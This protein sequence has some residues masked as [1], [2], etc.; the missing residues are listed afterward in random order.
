MSFNPRL[1]LQPPDMNSVRKAWLQ[2]LLV[3]VATMNLVDPARAQNLAGLSEGELRSLS[4]LQERVYLA[5]DRAYYYPGETVWYRAFMGYAMPTLRDT[6]SKVL[7]IEWIDAAGVIRQTQRVRIEKGAAWGNISLP[8]DYVSGTH[9]LRAYT[10]WMRNYS[11]PLFGKPISVLDL[12]HSVDPSKIDTVV[13]ASPYTVNFH[14]GKSSFRARDLVTL[15]ISVADGKGVPVLGNF[16]ISVVDTDAAVKIPG[17]RSILS[18]VLAVE[19]RPQVNELGYPI[20]RGLQIKGVVKDFRDRPASLNVNVVQ[21]RLED[22]VSFESDETG[23]FVLQDLNF[24][25][26][27]DFTFQATNKKSKP[28]GHVS[29]DPYVPP[30][31]SGPDPV[32]SLPYIKMDALQRIQNTYKAGDDVTVLEGV[33]VSAMRLLSQDE[34]VKQVKIYGKPD[35]TV[36][37]EQIVNTSAIH[38]LQAL[39]GKV[40]G[41]QI[42][43]VGNGGFTAK[44]R[45]GT[46]SLSG[47]SA[48]LILVDGVPWDDIST[49]GAINPTFV[50]R[51]EV[52]TRAVNTFGS[53][54]TN[55]VIAIYTKSGDYTPSEYSQTTDHFRVAGYTRQASFAAPDYGNPSVDNEN[56]DFRNTIYW[57][58][59]VIL[60]GTDPATVFFYCA[61]LETTYRVEV[62]GVTGM[63]I[64]FKGEYWLSVRK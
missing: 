6:L 52:V 28:A 38:V 47:N 36:M 30:K 26:S 43:P 20:E 42:V 48:P 25:D 59:C 58:P 40:P 9:T 4:A 7:Y 27:V 61:D 19:S 14:S 23:A 62:E 44:I 33:E 39:Q 16:S 8:S 35:Y 37:S 24:E 63:G 64:P 21:G 2:G 51:V 22:Y 18:G 11:H 55:G 34:R 57:N 54:G 56:P 60:N 10:A 49:L 32:P 13:F 5:T 29:L 45:G 41:L 53:R 46:S 17:R 15:A 50:D 3:F 12:S 31:F 1:P